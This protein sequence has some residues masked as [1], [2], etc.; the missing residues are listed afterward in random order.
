MT[1]KHF[2]ESPKQQQVGDLDQLLTDYYGPP[3]KEQPLP[4]AAWLDVQEQLTRRRRVRLH[5]PNWLAR[6][7]RPRRLVPFYLQESLRNVVSEARTQDRISLPRLRYHLRRRRRLP[8][9]DV[10]LWWPSAIHVTF[11]RGFERMLEQDELD[12]LLASGLAR[13]LCYRRPGQLIISRLLG[14]LTIIASLVLIWLIWKQVFSWPLWLALIILLGSLALA[15]WH[16]YHLALLADARVVRWL[17]RERSCQ[18][19]Q[20]LMARSAHPRRSGWA[21]PSLAAR[22]RRVC[23]L[24][25]STQIERLTTVR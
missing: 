22:A 2:D 8:T 19:L 1:H 14:L 13:H 21:E 15:G 9:I 17:G 7:R 11:S 25:A 16:K 12:F 5:G 6:A 4:P 20:G 18:G 10:S 3:L 24:P 23:T